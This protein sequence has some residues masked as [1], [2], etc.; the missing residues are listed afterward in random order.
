M[1]PKY[2]HF[3]F[4]AFLG[5]AV[6][7]GAP[8]MTQR[9]SRFETDPKDAA[10]YVD[11]GYVGRTPTAFHLPAKDQVRVRIELPTYGPIEEVLY[12]DPQTPKDAAEGVGWE[13]VYWYPLQPRRE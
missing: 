3:P 11:G 9:A 1:F 10:V 7:C 13:E 4:L 6:G 12:R 5:I 8:E 2:T